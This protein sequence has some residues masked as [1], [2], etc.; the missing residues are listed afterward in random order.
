MKKTILF[1]LLAV[2]F[3]TKMAPAK[4]APW[5][6]PTSVEAL[7]KQI[8]ARKGKVVLLNFWATWCTPCVAELPLLEKLQKQNSKKLSVMLVSADES[9][10]RPKAAQLLRQKGHSGASWIIAG[11]ESDFLKKF[12]PKSGDF[13]LP[14][15]YLFGR[16]GKLIKALT[17]D[18]SKNL[19]ATVKKLLK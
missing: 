5:P 9:S 8:V 12:D 14:R 18:E 6:A 3:S 4:P 17:A 19:E 11:N 7:K 1:L 15:T 2:P 16:D 10:D 13:A